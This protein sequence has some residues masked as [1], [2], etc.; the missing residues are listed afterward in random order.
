MA[1]RLKQTGQEVQGILD[2]MVNVDPGAQVNVIEELSLIEDNGNTTEV[3]PIDKRILIPTA[4]LT[5]SG[6]LGAKD[7][8]FIHKLTEAIGGGAD[9]FEL[10]RF[11][12]GESFPLGEGTNTDVWWCGAFSEDR[13]NE[14]VL[15]STCDPNATTPNSTEFQLLIA[16][17]GIFKRKTTNGTWEEWEALVTGG[18]IETATSAEMVTIWNET[19]NN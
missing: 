9:N 10:S 7:K 12:F 6:L 5:K 14:G 16:P 13:E 15:L 2:K 3:T 8:T 17:Y 19:N 11:D 4:T 18:E 1:Y